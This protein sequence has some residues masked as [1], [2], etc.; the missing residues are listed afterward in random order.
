MTQLQNALKRPYNRVLFAREVL[1]PIFGSNFTLNSPLKPA[2]M[3]P[4]KS[5]SASI[6]T[7]GIYGN[8]RLNDGTEITCYEVLLQ[9]QVRIEQNKVVVQQ[10]VRKLL[11]V[12]QAALI[13][14]IA[15]ANNNVWRFTLVARDSVFTEKG[16][17]EKPLMPNVIHSY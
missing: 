3:P 14:F 10:Y 7:V 16:V 4:N 12:G 5:E 11:T 17:K 1:A 13:N 2:P 9:P 8:I 15:P 6:D